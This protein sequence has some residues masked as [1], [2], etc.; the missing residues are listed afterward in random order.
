M[1]ERKL[2]GIRKNYLEKKRLKHFFKKNHLKNIFERKSTKN[3]RAKTAQ[4]TCETIL[5]SPKE[6]SGEKPRKN[7]KKK[8][9]EE[10][11]IENHL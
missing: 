8:I 10:Y 4:T 11:L 6:N 9:N 7:I 1:F 2:T 3:I 5:K